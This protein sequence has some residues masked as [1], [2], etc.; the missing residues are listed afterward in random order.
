MIKTGML[1]VVALVL[2]LLLP[3]PATGQPHGGLNLSWCTTD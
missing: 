1:L 3:I 2:A